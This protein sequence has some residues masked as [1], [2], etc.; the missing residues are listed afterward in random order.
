MSIT[1]IS[2]RVR[3]ASLAALLVVP[4]L[5]GCA[6]DDSRLAMSGSSLPHR[7][8]YTSV[9]PSDAYGPVDMDLAH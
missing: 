4:A 2:T 3:I 5:A 7:G 9:N 6:T 8:W 1:S